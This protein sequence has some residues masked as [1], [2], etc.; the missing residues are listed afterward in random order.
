MKCKCGD[1]RWVYV[2]RIDVVKDCMVSKV[3]GEVC[4]TVWDETAEERTVED[5]P[6]HLECVS[7]S[8]IKSCTILG[9]IY[10]E[11]D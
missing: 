9:R 2:E 10:V 7:C 3:D 1:D 4:I 11:H 6:S 8:H 5:A